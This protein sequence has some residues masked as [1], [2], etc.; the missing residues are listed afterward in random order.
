MAT[1]YKANGGVVRVFPRRG[2]VFKLKELQSVVDGY[3]Q[4][5]SMGDKHIAIMDEEGK[6][7]GKP[8]NE[9]ATALFRKHHNTEDTLV[10][11]VLLCN[12]NEIE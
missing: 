1:L 3:I 4:G 2:H 7:K 8:I 12:N 6:L 10:G 5:I 11:D 9:K